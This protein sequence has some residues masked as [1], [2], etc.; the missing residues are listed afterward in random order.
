M[1]DG[2]ERIPAFWLAVWIYRNRTW[3]EE[4]MP[5]ELVYT[6]FREFNIADE[7]KRRLF[8]ATPPINLGQWLGTAPVALD[9]LADY[10]GR[11]PDAKPEQG[12]TLALLEL[13][14]IGPSKTLTFEPADR[15][16]LITGD[17][18]LGK[19]FVLECAWWALTGSWP[20][21]ER[22]AY[23][24]F[25]AKRTEPSINF[26]IAGKLGQ[27][28]RGVASYD[29]AKDAWEATQDRP[30]LPGLIVYA[31]VDGS[32]AV[33][34]P[35][36][37]A[38]SDSA[39]VFRF[40]PNEVLRGLDGRIEGIL[41][42]WV[43]WQRSPDQGL[44]EMFRQVL[45]K[46]SPP[47]MDPLTPGEPRRLPGETKDIPTL[48]HPYGEVPFVFESAGVRRIVTIAYLL[49]WA[50][51]EHKTGAA[52]ARTEPQNRIA[53]LMDEVEA[54]LH[55]RW[56]RVV[57][58]AI[59]E[60]ASILDQEVEPQVIATTHSPLVLASLETEFSDEVDKLFHLQLTTSGDVDFSEIEFL[61]RGSA[62]AWLTSEVFELKEARST[63]A[64]RAI[65]RARELMA[66]TNPS[67]EEIRKAHIAL[68]ASLE[69]TDEFWPGWLYFAEKKGVAI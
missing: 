36:K 12:G 13:H 62:D 47:D 34:D 49:V 4:M 19:T 23:P 17:N 63:D 38:R 56:Q 22:P 58:P 65:G 29:W 46:V 55:P 10:A 6:L 43:T 45:K 51:D 1:R 44:F 3:N 20:D 60:V 67:S 54:H 15:L 37:S 64:E 5:A 52:M 2:I 61:R 42:D 33:W 7:E 21:P 50:W 31:R 18:G 53:L 41:R 32:F 16:S 57:L 48:V 11:P 69:S 9:L 26:Q 30:T 27:S 25:D 40:K 24:R 14:G 59:L 35:I 8:D 28:P 68:E 66:T 39:G